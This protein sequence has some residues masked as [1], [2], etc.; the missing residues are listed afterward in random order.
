[1]KFRSATELIAQ[2]SG[3]VLIHVEEKDASFL[4][5]ESSDDIGAD[6]GATAGDEDGLVGQ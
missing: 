3:A 4:S 5:H 1:V 6:A 2:P